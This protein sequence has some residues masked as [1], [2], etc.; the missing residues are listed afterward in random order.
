MASMLKDTLEAEI[1]LPGTALLKHIL[2]HMPLLTEEVR[3]LAKR[4]V[5]HAGLCWLL[6]LL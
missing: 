3:F 2:V 5:L 6:L 1:K 4:D